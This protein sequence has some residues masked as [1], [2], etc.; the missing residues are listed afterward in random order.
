MAQARSQ[1]RRLPGRKSGL[2][3]RDTLWLGP[4]HLLFVRS[5]RFT[6]DYRRFYLSDIQAIVLQQRPTGGRKVV[7]WA[8]IGLSVLAVALLFLT[9]HPVWGFLLAIIVAAYAWHALR[10]EDCKAW[11]QTAVGTAELPPL[12]RIG[13]T[14][15]A[16]AII[17]EKI[18]SA[19][20]AMSEEELSRALET[21]PPLPFLSAP[22]PP[23]VPPPLP[24]AVDALRAPSPL[25]VIAF[26][27]LLALG[28]LKMLT[29]LSPSWTF[30]W[31][32]PAGYLCFLA[33]SIVPLIRHGVKNIL[34][35]RA[36]AVFTSIVITGS[37]GTYAL[38]WAT[39][40]GTRKV[41][42]ADVQKMYEMLDKAAPLHVALAVVLLGL[43][44][45]GLLA[46]LT[47]SSEK[48]TDGTFTLFG[49]DRP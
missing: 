18:R 45:W 17:D 10:R 41:Q 29:A 32:M 12:C 3:R 40:Q 48:G 1:Y 36:V 21:P 44:I 7:D 22:S 14:R 20:A 47:A 43:A 38:S 34:G 28:V 15:K 26:V 46:F 35:V 30:V 42:A 11:L 23:A 24:A 19:Q 39:T 31:A 25:Y 9:D 8:A 6:E 27:W 16:L 49:A 37:I 5:S 4:D 13:S 2:L 33:L